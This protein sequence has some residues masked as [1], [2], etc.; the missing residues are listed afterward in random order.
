[1]RCTEAQP[2]LALYVDGAVTGGEMQ[3]IAEHLRQCAACASE[4]NGHENTR[5][6]VSSLGRKQVP[7]DLALRIRISVSHAR[8]RKFLH[9]LQNYGLRLRDAFNAIMFPATAGTLT[10]V[11]FFGILIGSFNL[12]QGRADNEIPTA[13]YTPPR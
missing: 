4:C 12:A 11:I 10:A 7:P 6:W 2:L 3:S 8:S 5:K 1:M 9:R 13:L